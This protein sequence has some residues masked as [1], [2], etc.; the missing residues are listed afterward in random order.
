M[1]VTFD[2]LAGLAGFL[3]PGKKGRQGSNFAR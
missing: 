3:L 2:G 1:S